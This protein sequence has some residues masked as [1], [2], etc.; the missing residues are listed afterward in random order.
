MSDDLD[1]TRRF[2]GVARLYGAHALPRLAAVR[3]TVVGIGGVGSWTAEALAR[4]GVGA[5]TLIDLDHL[6][7]SNINRQVH[8]LDATL[9]QAKGEA[10]RQ[11]IHDIN[12]ACH[13]QVIDDFLTPENAANLLART[14][15]VVD[16]IDNVRA[17]TALAAHCHAQRLPFMMCGGAGG[18]TQATRVRVADLSLT[19]ND[20]LLSKVRARLRKVH[21]FPS[22]RP[23]GKSQAFGVPAV[24]VDEAPAPPPATC[25]PDA[26]LNCA[27]YGS[28]VHVTATVGFVAAGWMIHRLLEKR[29]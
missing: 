5:L 25:S 19:V 4:S 14:D 27:G 29:L 23:G 7:L 9:G 18:K 1:S 28:V 6:A 22:G 8:A 10:M 11:R 12:P 24:F 26:P 16:A 21:G 2:G 3:V 15:A 17:K 20:P 13:V